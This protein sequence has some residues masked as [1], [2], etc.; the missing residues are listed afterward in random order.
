MSQPIFINYNGKILRQGT[1]VISADNRSF[2]YGDGCFETIKVK[3]RKLVLE[4]LHFERL[5]S[6]IEQ[7]QFSV[8][9]TFTAG[10][11]KEQIAALL[12]NNKH[13]QLARVRLTI[14]RGDG[15]LYDVENNF[16]N[17]VIQTWKLNENLE[18]L[19]ANGLVVGIYTNARKAID[20]FSH[21]KSNN[22]LCYV[23]AAIWARQQK[24]NE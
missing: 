20:A 13:E 18:Q 8:P 23:M 24:L 17:Y 19:N 5:F 2:R 11:L 21:I 22:F 3:N 4:E 12:K 14:F 6:S 10:L 1:P 15:G 16:P 9:K 7:L